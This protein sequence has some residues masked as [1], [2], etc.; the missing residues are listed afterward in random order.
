MSTF[1]L[2]NQRLAKNC[3]EREE[4]IAK[5]VRES[6]ALFISSHRRGIRQRVEVKIDEEFRSDSHPR[7]LVTDKEVG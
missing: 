1:C 6:I 3:L 2:S 4:L 5:A 7:D